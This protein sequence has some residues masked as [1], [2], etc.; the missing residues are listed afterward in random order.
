[1]CTLK[2]NQTLRLSA[3]E[4]AELETVKL[5]T[6]KVEKRFTELETVELDLLAYTQVN[7]QS[8]TGQCLSN[9]EC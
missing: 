5:K 7:S 1:M 9:R 3:I 4:A 6:G 2:E 8:A